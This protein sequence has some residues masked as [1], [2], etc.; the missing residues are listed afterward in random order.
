MI[1]TKTPF[2]ISFFGGGTDYPVWYKQHGGA[3][4]STTI[5]KYCYIMCRSL[6]PFF[7]HKYRISYSKF[8]HVSNIDEIEHP[9]VRESIRFM[10]IKEGLEIHHDA[11]L[12]ARSGLGSS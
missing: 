2:R 7:D 8:E 1:I 3:V 6:P 9:A 12:P 4:L 11:D 10:S 5:N